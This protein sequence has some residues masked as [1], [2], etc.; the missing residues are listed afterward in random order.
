M[1]LKPGNP[2]MPVETQQEL[3]RS[4]T[5]DIKRTEEI[6]GRDLSAWLSR[7]E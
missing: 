4:Y 6:L 2:Q 1:N 7:G 3:L 5:E